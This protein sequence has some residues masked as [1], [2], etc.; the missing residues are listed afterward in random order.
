M[1]TWK[2][3]EVSNKAVNESARDYTA[4]YTN[5]NKESLGSGCGSVG[6]A[7][8]SNSSCPRFEPSHQKIENEHL[9]TANCT[10]RRK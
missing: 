7:V 2:I 5:T 3:L 8:A 1:N 6:K 10:E 9:F 4:D